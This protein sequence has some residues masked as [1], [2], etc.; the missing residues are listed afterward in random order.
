L[1]PLEPAPKVKDAYTRVRGIV[2]AT[3]RDMPLSN[4]IESLVGLV[5]CLA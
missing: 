4:Y 2:P 1:K 5:R 3:D